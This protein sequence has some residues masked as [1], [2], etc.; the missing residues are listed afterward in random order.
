MLK[1][2]FIGRD[3]RMEFHHP[4]KGVV[5]TS[6]VSDIREQNASSMTGTALMRKAS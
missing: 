4:E 5:R 1:L 2:R 6:R 3:M